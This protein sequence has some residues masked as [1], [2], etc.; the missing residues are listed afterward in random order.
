MLFCSGS[1]ILAAFRNC[2]PGAYSGTTC[3]PFRIGGG[4]TGVCADA[5]TPKNKQEAR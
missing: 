4:V 5:V 1:P 2:E 3:P